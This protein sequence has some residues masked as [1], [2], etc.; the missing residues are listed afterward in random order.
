M[1]QN[2]QAGRDLLQA[3]RDY[4]NHI[5]INILSGKWGA[6]FISLIPL[7]L[8]FYIVGSGMQWAVNTLQS[9]VQSFSGSRTLTEGSVYIIRGST[10]SP[11][12]SISA[13]VARPKEYKELVV[14]YINNIPFSE[15]QRGLI[16][17]GQNSQ[18]DGVL[19]LSNGTYSTNTKDTDLTLKLDANPIEKGEFV[20]GRLYGTITN[21]INNKTIYLKFVIPIQN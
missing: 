11:S 20:H 19:G 15:Y 3:G 8:T 7:I 16:K 1:S 12:V 10:S 2:G 9:Q 4:I 6:V 5:Q 13:S 21:G 18:A 14:F 17:L